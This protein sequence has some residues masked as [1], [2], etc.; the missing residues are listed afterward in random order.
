MQDNWFV[1]DSPKDTLRN[2]IASGDISI[3][4]QAD[5]K[6]FHGLLSDEVSFLLPEDKDVDQALS[7]L[8]EHLDELIAFRDSLG[9]VRDN[10]QRRA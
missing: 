6:T 3:L 2:L 5:V 4:Q 10:E 8:E 7:Y 1:K 9:A